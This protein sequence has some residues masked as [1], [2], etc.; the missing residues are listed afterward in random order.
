VKEVC[1]LVNTFRPRFAHQDLR[2][3]VSV[4][5][6]QLHRHAAGAQHAKHFFVAYIRLP[7]DYQHVYQVVDIRQ[8]AAVPLGNRNV[9]VE[10]ERLNVAAC[11]FDLVRIGVESLDHV[12]IVSSQGGGQTAVATVEMDDQAALYPGHL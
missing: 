3:R 11:G 2:L 6:F 7:A 12:V 1:P 9:A 5:G 10:S 4:R 8:P